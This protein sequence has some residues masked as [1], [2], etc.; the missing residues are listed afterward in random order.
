MAGNFREQVTKR[1]TR[2][3]GW[4]KFSAELIEEN[5]ACSVCGKTVKV[6]R[7]YRMQVHHKKPFHLFR[8]LEFSKENCA[9]VCGN[10]RCHLDKGHLGD[11]KSWNPNFEEDAETWRKKYQERP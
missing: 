9:V 5:P 6:L 1:F 11:F 3:P 8:E 2:S 7:R 10:P 4:S